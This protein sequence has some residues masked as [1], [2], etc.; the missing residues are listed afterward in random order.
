MTSIDSLVL[1]LVIEFVILRALVPW[2]LGKM[3]SATGMTI[4]I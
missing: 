3:N 1:V 2:I 4:P